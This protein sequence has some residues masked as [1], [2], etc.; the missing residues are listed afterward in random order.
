M[1]LHINKQRH[2]LRCCDV[3]VNKTFGQTIC[4]CP[5]L[6]DESPVDDPDGALQRGGDGGRRMAPGA[7]VA[8]HGL[9]AAQQEDHD[10]HH[11]DG[12]SDARPH[13]QVKGRQQR[14]DVDLLL[15]LA[16]ENPHRVVQ[17][18]LAEVHH[19]LALRRDG[20]G[21]DGQVGTLQKIVFSSLQSL[22]QRYRL[23][24]LAFNF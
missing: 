10:A 14:E 11:G 21:R 24:L 1:I 19:A 15:R 5:T 2:E 13:G 6:L 16:H 3:K 17:V 8:A 23:W 22:I 20:D 4:P 9:D 12:S 18:A 7:A